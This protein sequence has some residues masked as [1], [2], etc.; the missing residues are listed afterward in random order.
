M[1]FQY[2]LLG[3]WKSVKVSVMNQLKIDSNNSQHPT[4]I[5]DPR[6]LKYSFTLLLFGQNLSIKPYFAM[7]GEQVL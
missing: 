4:S 2:E 5:L 3:N 1:T 6:S 7:S